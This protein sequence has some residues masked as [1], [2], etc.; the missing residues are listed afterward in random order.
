MRVSFFSCKDY[1]IDFLEK[2]RRENF[3][4]KYLSFPLSLKTVDNAMGSSIVSVFSRDEL[5]DAVLTRLHTLKVK[6]VSTRSTGYNH[7]D[8]DAAK[9]LGIQIAHVPDYSPHAI[10]EHAILLILALSKKLITSYENQKINNYSLEG[11]LGFN[12]GEKCVGIVGTGRIGQAMIQILNGFGSEVLAYD[13]NP[14]KHLEKKLN[15]QYV[16]L[17]TLLETSDIIS[18]HIPLNRD[19]QYFINKDKLDKM[20][21]GV[22]LINTSRGKHLDT[23]AVL[24][25]INS[26]KVS[27]LGIDVYENED[28]IFFENHGSEP[29]KDSIFLQLKQLKNVYITGHQAFLTE[30]ALDNIAKTTFDN[31][32]AFISGETTENFLV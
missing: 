28:N 25:A 16:D 9:R 14:A 29:I 15:F 24:Q 12:L 18:L 11:L 19:N 22:V 17:D 20:K 8:L 10:A 2:H 13:I 3:N 7:I 32:Q 30:T 1:E 4:I 31:I 27:A 21:N 6:F 23:A 26:K 5:S